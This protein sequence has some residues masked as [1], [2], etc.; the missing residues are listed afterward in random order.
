M[1]ERTAKP[2]QHDLFLALLIAN[3]IGEPHQVGEAGLINIR[4]GGAFFEQSQK[5]YLGTRKWRE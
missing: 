3:G 4:Y 1:I 2:K 5:I